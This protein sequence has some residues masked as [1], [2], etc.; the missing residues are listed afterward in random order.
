MIRAKKIETDKKDWKFQ[1]GAVRNFRIV[2]VGLF[3][4]VMFEQRL[5]GSKKELVILMSG[6][7]HFRKR[8]RK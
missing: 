5:E 7:N 3:E 6:G 2:C 1:E 4:K 8:E